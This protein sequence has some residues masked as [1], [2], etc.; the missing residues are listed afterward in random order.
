MVN[1]RMKI[2]PIFFTYSGGLRP[3]LATGERNAFGDFFVVARDADQ[4]AEHNAGGEQ[5]RTAVAHQ[6]Q[7]DAFGRQQSG[8]HHHVDQGLG[9]DHQGDAESEQAAEAVLT[10]LA[11]HHAADKDAEKQA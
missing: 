6:R 8:D 5:V 2:V 10:R 4:D 11:D 3:D 1:R 7:R 9:G